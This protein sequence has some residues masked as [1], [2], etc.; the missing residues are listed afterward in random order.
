VARIVHRSE[1]SWAAAVAD[2]M[3]WHATARDEAAEW[4]GRSA[5]ESA[6]SK[7][8][9][10]GGSNDSDAGEEVDDSGEESGADAGAGSEAGDPAAGAANKTKPSGTIG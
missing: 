4:P 1:A 7:A 2:L 8:G 3:R 5:Q 10:D 6:I 9:G